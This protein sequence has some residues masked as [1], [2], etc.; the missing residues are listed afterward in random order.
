M[1]S[2]KN[3]TKQTFNLPAEEIADRI[4]GRGFFVSL[5]L[6]G[7]RRARHLNFKWRQKT[8]P[9][10]VLS[11]PLDKHLGEIFLNPRRASL[12]AKR[13]HRQNREHLLS[14]FIHAL[15]HLKGMDHSSKMSQEE[16][17]YLR[18]FLLNEPK[19]HHRLGYRHSRHQSGRL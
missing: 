19:H 7:D 8:Y 1:L 9:A 15:L 4:L 12:E 13:F 11:F 3:L 6:I 2:L 18:L 14:L 17:K 16:E 10:N 5:V